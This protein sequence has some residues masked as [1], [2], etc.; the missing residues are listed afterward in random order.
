MRGTS[1]AQMG[2]SAV[3]TG[4]NVRVG[5]NAPV[6]GGVG[7]APHP[8]ARSPSSG[9]VDLG[10]LGTALLAQAALV[11]LIALAVERVLA[12]VGGGLHQRPAQV[13]RTG[14][15]QMAATVG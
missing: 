1:S 12:G 3:D 15:G 14:V 5:R 4:C 8:P 10:D 2:S 6:A 9:E 11:A 13:L 7:G